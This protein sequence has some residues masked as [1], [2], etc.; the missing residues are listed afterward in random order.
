MM[1]G[2]VFTIRNA[3][4]DKTSTSNLGYRRLM[5]TYDMAI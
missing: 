3:K 4:F 5:N 2:K 1:K